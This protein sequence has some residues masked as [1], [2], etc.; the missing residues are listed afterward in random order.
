M[1]LVVH[2]ALRRA[3][4]FAAQRRERA[5]TLVSAGIRP[6]T[7][8]DFLSFVHGMSGAPVTHVGG[9]AWQSCRWRDREIRRSASTPRS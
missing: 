6:R 8:A 9:M 3:A 2:F 1:I 7:V 5:T 4:R